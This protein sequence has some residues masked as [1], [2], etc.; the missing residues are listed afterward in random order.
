MTSAMCPVNLFD[1]RQAQAQRAR[2]PGEVPVPAGC[3]VCV[4]TGCGPCASPA[5]ACDHSMRECR[6]AATRCTVR[7]DCHEYNRECTAVC[8]AN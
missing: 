8:G 1:S 6:E 7:H 4:G 5:V 2:K 3:A